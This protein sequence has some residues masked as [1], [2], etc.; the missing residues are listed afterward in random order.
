MGMNETLPRPEKYSRSL[1]DTR[2]VSGA[3]GPGRAWLLGPLL[4]AAGT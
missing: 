1:A 4:K 3:L 2:A